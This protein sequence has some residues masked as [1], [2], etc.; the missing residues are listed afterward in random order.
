MGA[1]LQAAVIGL[2][3]GL[4][5]VRFWDDGSCRVDRLQRLAKLS[6]PNPRH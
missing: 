3:S 4:K 2:A 5:A 1:V 6:L